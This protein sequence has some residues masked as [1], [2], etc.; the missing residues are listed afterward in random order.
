MSSSPTKGTTLKPM[1]GTYTAVEVSAPSELRVVERRVA[2]LVLVR[3]GFASRRAGFAI[4]IPLL[5]KA[6]FRS[7]G[8]ASPGMK[9]S[10]GSMLLAPVSRAGRLASAWVSA[11]S[12]ALA[13]IA[14]SVE[15]GIS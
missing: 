11:S 3:F 9:R 5:W 13:V 12:E 10:G 15:M 14:S 4:P 2:G 6:Y 7:I 8:R 1:P